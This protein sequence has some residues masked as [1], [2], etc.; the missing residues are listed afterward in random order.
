MYAGPWR[1][2]DMG[3]SAVR[4]RPGRIGG[5][6]CVVETDRNPDHVGAFASE[7]R[8]SAAEGP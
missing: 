5:E 1:W 3:V 2:G 6:G 4:V 8:R 7:E